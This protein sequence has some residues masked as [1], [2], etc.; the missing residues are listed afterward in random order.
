M[1][2]NARLLALMVLSSVASPWGGEPNGFRFVD[3][4][5]QAGIHAQIVCGGPEKK[6]IPEANGSGVA[7]LDYDNDRWMDLLIVNGSTMEQLRKIVSGGSSVFSGNGVYL[8]RN[9]SNG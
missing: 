5:T 1:A 3:T 2:L 8:Y 7:W 4:A 6:W 9:L